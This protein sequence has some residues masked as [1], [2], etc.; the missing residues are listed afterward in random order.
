MVAPP[1]PATE[2]AS[3][4]ATQSVE[5]AGEAAKAL[6]PSATSSAVAAP[7]TKQGGADQTGDA[8]NAASSSQSVAPAPGSN[9]RLADKTSEAQQALNADADAPAITAN[10]ETITQ[11]APPPTPKAAAAA[12]ADLP[13]APPQVATANE[14]LQP[15]AASKVLVLVA[16]PEVKSVAELRDKSVLIAGV[17]SVPEEQLKSALATAGASGAKFK[18]GGKNDIDPLVR[19]EVAAVIVDLVS[20]ETAS[21][22]RNV[23]FPGLRLLFVEVAPQA[24]P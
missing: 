5:T 24:K 10:D 16:N 17:A 6:A 19:G 13:G 12:N 22:V 7:E 2:T 18:Q 8:A 15:P 21:S 11:P 14:G 4:S 9:E 3:K 1:Q 20:P 23:D